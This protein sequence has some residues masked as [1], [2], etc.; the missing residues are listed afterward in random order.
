[1][2]YPSGLDVGGGSGPSLDDYLCGNV[3]SVTIPEE[4]TTLDPYLF[5]GK[6]GLKGVILHDKVTSIGDRAFSGCSDL[7][8]LQNIDSVKSYGSGS[9]NG[10]AFEEF[11]FPEAATTIGS[12]IFQYCQKLKRVVFSEGITKIPSSAICNCNIIEE[13]VMGSKVNTIDSY[14]I[15]SCSSLKNLTLS[16]GLENIR[17]YAFQYTAIEELTIPAS[18]KL[19]YTNALANMSSLTKVTFE[20]PSNWII[21]TSSYSMTGD[22]IDLSDPAQNAEYLKSTY[23]QKYFHHVT[24]DDD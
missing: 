2:F 18:V 10:T 22:S 17:A 11:I 6:R 16:A 7:I 24:D 4:L 3:T 21:N 20:D 13:V 14:G 19:I 9:L 15:S 8:S 23:R 5:Y 12:Y 1:M